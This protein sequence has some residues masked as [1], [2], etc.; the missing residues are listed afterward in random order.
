MEK[1]RPSK[2]KGELEEKIREAKRTSSE[3]HSPS[4]FAKKT[5]RDLSLEIADARERLHIAEDHFTNSLNDHARNAFV[6]TRKEE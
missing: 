4:K 6:R 5:P 2:E 1:N 3:S